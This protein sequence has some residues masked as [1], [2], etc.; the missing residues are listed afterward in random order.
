MS[1][2]VIEIDFAGKTLDQVCREF[3][4]RVIDAAMRASNYRKGRAAERLGILR[5]RLRRRL[6]AGP[7]PA[8]REA[9]RK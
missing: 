8:S 2:S 6:E 9:A 1:G 3:E 4:A 7:P 5:E